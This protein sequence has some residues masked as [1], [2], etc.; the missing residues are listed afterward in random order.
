V[1]AGAFDAFVAPFVRV[2]VLK[3]HLG[4][5]FGEVT[6]QTLIAQFG[7]HVFGW[8][9]PHRFGLVPGRQPPQAPYD[10]EDNCDKD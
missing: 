3:L 6:F 7:G 2:F 8:G 5:C 1:A 4:Q 9:G 10:E